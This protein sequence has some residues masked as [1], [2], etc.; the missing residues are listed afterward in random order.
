LSERVYWKHVPATS[1]ATSHRY[2]PNDLTDR[3]AIRHWLQVM[4]F[5]VAFVGSSVCSRQRAK[6]SNSWHVCARCFC[7]MPISINFRT[8]LCSVAGDIY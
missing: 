5:S 4:L 6:Q 3:E 7:S 8:L 1:E 2:S